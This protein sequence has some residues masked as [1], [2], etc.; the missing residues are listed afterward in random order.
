MSLTRDMTWAALSWLKF[1][2]GAD[3]VC[4]EVGN[5]Y[6]KDA[7]GLWIGQDGL[8]TSMVEIEVK[9]S[10]DDI[11]RD[12]YNKTKKHEWYALGRHAPNYLYYL[13]PKSIGE[14]AKEYI[15]SKNM[16]YG[17]IAY[18]SEN[19]GYMF[20]FK[21]SMISIHRCRKLTDAKPSPAYLAQMCR[22]LTNEYLQQKQV[23]R[24]WHEHVEFS[25]KHYSKAIY[26][27]ERGRPDKYNPLG[28]DAEDET[29]EPGRTEETSETHAGGSG[30]EPSGQEQNQ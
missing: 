2:K 28:L 17:V 29:N 5:H 1:E 25:V 7:C 19:D 23:I 16:K 11:R 21:T 24:S 9:T 30:S 15:N 10:M 14:S 13:V 12:F 22:R 20:S 26:K 4:T 8:P 3:I 27:L 18:D 6:L